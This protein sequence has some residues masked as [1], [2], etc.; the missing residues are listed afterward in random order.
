MNPY[1]RDFRLQVRSRFAEDSDAMSMSEYIEKN[2]K[3]RK[4]QFSFQGYEFQRD[5]VD[6]MHRNMVVTKCS[7]IGL[8]EVQ[9]RKFAAFLARTTAINGIFSLP[10]DNMMK[11]VSQTRFGP[12][13]QEGKVFNLGF[14]KPIRSI[15]LYQI[16]QSFGYFT[17]NKESDATSINADFLFHDE[18]DLSDQ[19]MIAL[20]QSRLQGS[21]YRITQS[22]STPTFEG[23]GIDAG[24]KASDQ[25]EYLLKCEKCNHH[26][27][28]TFTP[29]H[30]TIPGLPSDLNDL[31]EIDVD[32]AARLNLGEAYL[33]C[34]KCGSKLNLH[35]PS[36]RSWVPRHPG[37]LGRGYRVSPFCTPRLTIEYMIEQLLLYKQKDALRRFYNTVL[38]E[39]FNDS[40]ARISEESILACM[41]SE[42][43]VDLGQEPVFV[44]IDAG[45]TCHIILIH[46]GSKNPTIFDFRQVLA[47]N[48]YDEIETIL[49]TYNVIGG[50][51]DRNPYTPLANDIRD[52]SDGRIVPV[53]YAGSPTAAAVQIVTDELD[54][55]SHIRANRTTMIDAVATAIRKRRIDM[56]GYQN[57]QHLIIQHLRDMVRIEKD[58]T[59][60]VWQK[61]SGNDHY[62]HAIGYALYALRTND[63][64]NYNSDQDERLNFGFAPIEAVLQSAADMGMQSRRKTPIFLGQI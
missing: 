4:K 35:D 11:R 53:E 52:L 48:L 45:I 44:G 22:F 46:M 31:I 15:Q 58:D 59:S 54:N 30:I 21:D 10:D 41:R 16:N 3:L 7:Q 29:D 27:L 25:H 23:F 13:I 18:L 26:N 1:I 37:R 39:P 12:M 24:F 49:S 14:D 43:K 63:A 50:V 47:D 62:F 9:L 5:I 36:L 64:L 60:A 51:M 6:D 2:T 38:G 61:L 32:I 55:L 33:R 42:R 57:Q 17:G 20:F 40:N 28:P 8:T 19:E 56:V 34:D